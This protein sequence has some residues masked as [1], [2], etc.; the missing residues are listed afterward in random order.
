MIPQ[1]PALFGKDDLNQAQLVGKVNQA[2]RFQSRGNSFSS[3]K[4]FHDVVRNDRF[5]SV[6]FYR[7]SHFR[8]R[9]ISQK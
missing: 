1:G 7:S 3:G 8:R 6:H 9:T 5:Q 4:S 2:G